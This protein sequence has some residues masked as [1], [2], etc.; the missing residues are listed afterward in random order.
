[1][2]RL[3]KEKR[4]IDSPAKALAYGLAVP[5]GKELGSGRGRC[6]RRGVSPRGC[7]GR[8][9]SVQNQCHRLVRRVVFQGGPVHRRRGGG[10]QEPEP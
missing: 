5:V 4:G 10:K 3:E 2:R 7:L 8:C 9:I 6:V 1:M